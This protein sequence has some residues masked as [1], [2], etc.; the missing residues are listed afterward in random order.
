MA[1]QKIVLV[2]SK[3]KIVGYKEKFACHKNP[4]PLHRAI[5]VVIY[6]KFHK[7][8]LLQ[9]RSSVKP[10]WPLYWSNTCCSHPYDGES[11]REAG[12]RRLKEEM[13][14]ETSLR[15][16]FRFKYSKEFNKT[17]GENELDTVLTGEY[18]GMIKPDPEE[19]ADFKW[20]NIADLNTDIKANANLYTPWFIEIMD[21]LN[22]V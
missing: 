7:K 6:D 9:K 21:R 20:M 22:G 8:I 13:G 11:Y 18:E 1:S 2:N 5:S 14:I 10:T 16:Q 4:V 12:E 15:V 19:A 17:W 3:D